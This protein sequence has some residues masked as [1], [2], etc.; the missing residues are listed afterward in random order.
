MQLLIITTIPD[1]F[2]EDAFGCDGQD[3]ASK[4]KKTLNYKYKRRW[5]LF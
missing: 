2:G 4:S 3:H 5:F 1:H